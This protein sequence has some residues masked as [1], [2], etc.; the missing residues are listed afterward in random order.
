MRFAAY[1]E[2]EKRRETSDWIG[3][4]WLDWLPGWLDWRPT[5]ELE[6]RRDAGRASDGA[7]CDDRLRLRRTVTVCDWRAT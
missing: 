3:L 7:D 1:G 6:S 2:K 4:D 5:F